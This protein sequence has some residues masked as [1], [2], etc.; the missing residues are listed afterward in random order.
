M[1]S[2]DV[3]RRELLAVTAVTGGALVGGQLMPGI[4]SPTTAQNAGA[5]SAPLNVSLR[6][7]GTE[8]RLTLD[9]RT[10]LLFIFLTLLLWLRHYENLARLVAGTEGKIGRKANNA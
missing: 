10:T 3:T 5:A 2:Y 8:H 7:N 9:P 4:I 6:V 1:A